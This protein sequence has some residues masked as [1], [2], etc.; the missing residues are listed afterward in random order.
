MWTTFLLPEAQAGMMETLKETMKQVTIRSVSLQ[1]RRGRTRRRAGSL[2]PEPL[3]YQTARYHF[4]NTWKNKFASCA[5]GWEKRRYRKCTQE[6]SRTCETVESWDHVANG[7]Q[8]IH[9]L[10]PQRQARHCN[11]WHRR[12]IQHDTLRVNILNWDKLTLAWSTTRRSWRVLAK[13]EV[14]LPKHN[15]LEQLVWKS[16]ERGQES[17]DLSGSVQSNT[18]TLCIF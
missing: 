11:Q 8:K 1:W 7:P 14:P 12:R 13:Q 6:S 4:Q 10:T 15:N 18:L 17:F 16:S 2:T 9:K 5:D 3:D